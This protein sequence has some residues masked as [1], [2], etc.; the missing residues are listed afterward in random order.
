MSRGVL[1]AL[2]LGLLVLARAHSLGRELLAPLPGDDDHLLVEACVRSVPALEE[3]GWRFDARLRFLRHAQW[4]VRDL[5]VQLPAEMPGPEVGE[6]WQ[7]AA[8][9]SQPRELAAR[10]VL[11]RDHLSGYA[12]VD[13]GPLNRR[14]AAGGGGLDALRARLARRIADRVEDPAAAALLAALAVG[15]TGEVSTRQW[16]VFNATGITHLVAISGMHVTFLALLAMVAAR[17]CWRRLAPRPWLPRRAAFAA[18]AG[19]TLALLYALLSGFSVP[20]QRT[21]VML[22]AFLGAREC[23][24]RTGAAWSVGVAL[25]AVLLYDP[26]AVLGAGFWLSFAAVIAI[27][28]LAGA[29]LRQA[30]ML[31][32]AVQLQWLVSI[33]LLPVTVAIFGSF[34]AM[35]LLA[36]LLAIPLFTLLLVPPVLLATVCCLLPGATAAWCADLLLWLAGRVAT[37]MWPALSW[38]ADLP[39]ALWH[40]TPPWSWYLLALPAA[41]LALLPLAP[42]MRI[43]GLALLA[44][45]F[46]LRA[47]RPAAGELWIDARGQGAAATLLLRTRQHLLLVGTGEVYRSDG[48]RLARQLLPLLRASGYPRIDLWLPGNLTRDAQ[49]ALR[50]AAAEL[51]VQRVLLEPG[52]DVPPEFHPCAAASWRWDGINFELRDA[53][54]GC[55][56]VVASGARELVLGEDRG[57]QAGAHSSSNA[58]F[59]F[60]DNGLSLRATFLRL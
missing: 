33:T 58:S 47:P 8:R 51:Q 22:A 52:K 53:G 46:L 40:A 45:A 10:R 26:M 56:L 41:L 48:R 27:V 34:S 60:S 4:P 57:M 50:L 17:H 24:R 42:R 43:A 55:R 39:G 12:R 38:C 32:A 59:K 20:A 16:Q 19:V 3:S 44:S 14:I 11:L 31:P 54:D 23:A 36:N 21:V 5:R 18:L 30:A 29:R 35:G 37:A 2:G 6:C 1:L 7:Y 9:L 25:V 13:P 49:V 15:V 28:L